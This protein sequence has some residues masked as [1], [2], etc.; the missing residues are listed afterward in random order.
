MFIPSKDRPS[1]GE[2]RMGVQI[3][4]TNPGDRVKLR[5]AINQTKVSN[6]KY[7]RDC[8][9]I[10]GG[11]M[12]G[13]VFTVS[14]VN[15]RELWIKIEIPGRSPPAFLKVTGAELSSNFDPAA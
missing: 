11:I 3:N 2:N 12:P 1:V 4:I 10:G 9:S 14:D 5:L 6:W 15:R 13:T 7:A 8:D